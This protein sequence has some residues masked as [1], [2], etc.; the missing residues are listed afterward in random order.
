[1]ILLVILAAGITAGEVAVL[2]VGFGSTL[3]FILGA[4][5]LLRR[6]GRPALGRVELGEI[7]IE[8]GQRL[9]HNLADLAQRMALRHPILEVN[10]AE[11]RPAA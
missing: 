2:G 6:D 9:V 3:L 1:M 8:R 11:Q 10:E 4:Q 7:A 5:Q